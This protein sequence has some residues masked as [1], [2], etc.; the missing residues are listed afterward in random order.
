MSMNNV[1]TFQQITDIVGTH[2]YRTE[3]YIGIIDI[4]IHYHRILVGKAVNLFKRMVELGATEE[5]LTR[6]AE[7]ALVCIDT[8][9][10]CLD[11]K[12]CRADNGIAALEK[13][14][15]IEKKD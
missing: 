10:H 2:D 3:Y 15:P 7:Y 12:K 14:Y 6:A 11:Y 1:T 9:K 13:K 5:E 4:N 8:M